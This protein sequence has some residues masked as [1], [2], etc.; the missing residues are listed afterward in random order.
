VPDRSTVAFD[1]VQHLRRAAAR[2]QAAK[3]SVLTRRPES[4]GALQFQPS[5]LGTNRCRRPPLDCPKRRDDAPPLVRFAKRCVLRGC[6]T[7]PS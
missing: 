4:L 1:V 5:S 3:Q 6:S 2:I 7:A